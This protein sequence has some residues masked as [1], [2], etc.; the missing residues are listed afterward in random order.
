[1]NN[2]LNL[3]ETF[4]KKL[5]LQGKSFNTI[6]NYRTDLKCFSKFLLEFKKDLHL[7]EFTTTQA[8]EYA[9][10]LSQKYSSDNSIRRRI[11]ALR[12]FFDFL[13]ENEQFPENPIKKVA[14]SPKVVERPNPVPYYIIRNV[15]FHL[16]SQ[17]ENGNTMESL[18]AIRNKLLIYFIYGAG[19][20]VSEIETLKKSNILKSK[21][22]E[23]R[24]L[25]TH[26]KKEPVTITLPKDFQFV[27][28]EYRKKLEKQMKKDQIDFNEILFNANPFKILSGGL[29]ARG[30]EIIFK[31]FSKLMNHKITPRALRQSCI[32][33]WLA[34]DI[35]HSR[36]KE[37]MGVQPSYSLK[38]FVDLMDEF[39]AITF[40]EPKES[41][42]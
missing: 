29:S 20:K 33:K 35:N 39:Q 36:I 10:Y 22:G 38:P 34:Q 17:I 4:L 40:L 8:Q 28:D 1:M 19:L 5:Q 2:L 13:V 42:V 24:V 11:Q 3:Q 12:L 21:K 23:L 7:T 32:F 26:P 18:L 25:I 15:V 16:N 27:Y 30:I 9:R 37:W 41:V 14:V 31:D 6:K